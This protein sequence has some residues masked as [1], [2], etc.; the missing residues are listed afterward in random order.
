MSDCILW[1]GYLSGGYGREGTGKLAHRSAWERAHGPIPDEMVIHHVC[2]VKNC[3][4]VEHLRCI[5]HLEHNRIHLNASSDYAR[6]RAITHC[7]RG[8]EYSPSN[9]IYK[10]TGA[11]RCRACDRERSRLYQAR[12]RLALG[13]QERDGIG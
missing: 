5:S 9:T 12:R 8:H 3:V 2:E 4:N 10:V 7:P 11:R 1:T 6:R 13:R